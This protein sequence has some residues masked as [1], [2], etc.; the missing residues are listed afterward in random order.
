[1]GP[2]GRP[3]QLGAE[4]RA[5]SSS[6]ST[7]LCVPDGEDFPSSSRPKPEPGPCSPGRGDAGLCSQPALR[8]GVSEQGPAGVPLGV[9]EL[10]WGASEPPCSSSATGS[11]TAHDVRCC[12]S[13]LKQAAL[14]T[15]TPGE[16][17]R[18]L[19]GSPST[20]AGS[21]GPLR[22]IGCVGAMLSAVIPRPWEHP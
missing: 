21:R 19:L 6:C 15:E 16:K 12:N 22:P 1:M 14:A 11:H 13:V 3:A 20:T 8:A 2:T 18:C 7:R 10:L 17:T 9:T 4:V 5:V